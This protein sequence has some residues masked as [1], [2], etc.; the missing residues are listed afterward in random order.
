MKILSSLVLIQIVAI[1]LLYSKLAGIEEKFDQT[2]TVEQ[3]PTVSD[4][5]VT[6]QPREYPDDPYFY[7]DEDRLRQIIRE[8]L[9]AHVDYQGGP[10]SESAPPVVY[11]AAEIAEYEDRRERVVQQLDYYTSVGSI[12]DVEMQQLHGEIATLDEAGQKEMLSKLTRAMNS[13]ELSGRL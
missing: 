12:S 7:A 1:V 8:E 5:I 10:A 9:G 11:S 13:G 6:T 2:T 4:A 3:G